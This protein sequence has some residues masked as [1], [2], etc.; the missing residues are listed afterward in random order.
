MGFWR[1][2]PEVFWSW[3]EINAKSLE[4]FIRSPDLTTP[5]VAEP[6]LEKTAKALAAYDKRIQPLFGLAGDGMAEIVLTT[7]GNA[8]AFPK[9]F[10]LVKTAP[11]LP[12]WRFVALKPRQQAEAVSV[13]GHSLGPENLR[14][15]LNTDC[16]PPFVLLLAD[17]D[18][19]ESFAEHQIMGMLLIELLLGEHDFATKVGGVAV[20]SLDKYVATHGHVGRP[21]PELAAA[22]GTSRAN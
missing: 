12:G 14:F 16:E 19:T 7:E 20:V 15:H 10:E 11:T 1:K 13:N 2:G 9:V 3:F 22:V 8:A 4:A 18:V 17:R 21:F 5:A 6:W